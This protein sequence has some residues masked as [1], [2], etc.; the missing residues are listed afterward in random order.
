MKKFLLFPVLALSLAACQ[1]SSLTQEEQAPVVT[2]IYTSFTGMHTEMEASTSELSFVGQSSIVNHEGKFNDF[3]VTIETDKENPA[4]LTKGTITVTAEVASIKTD[5]EGLDEHLQKEEFFDAANFPTVT[6]ET[7]F[8]TP[9][10]DERF[11][12]TGEMTAKGVTKTL[13][14]EATITDKVLTA[15]FDFPRKDFG[16]GN[17]SYGDKLLS[18]TVPVTVK[19]VFQ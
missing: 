16:I 2:K 12:L 10:Q 15:T 7:T 18:D 13:S 8:I 4:D 6:F 11:V 14:F 19:V 9:V 17:A 1:T 3:S 5:S